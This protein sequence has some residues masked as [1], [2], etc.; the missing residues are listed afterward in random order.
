RFDVLLC[1]GNEIGMQNT[2]FGSEF[3]RNEKFEQRTMGW[4]IISI[5][6]TNKHSLTHHIIMPVIQVFLLFYAWPEK[7]A[8]AIREMAIVQAHLIRGKHFP[9]KFAQEIKLILE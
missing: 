9:R 2:Q 1:Q 3:V 8:N 5:F 6:V 4:P 7:F